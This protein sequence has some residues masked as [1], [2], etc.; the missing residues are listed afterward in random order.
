MQA[1]FRLGIISFA[2][3]TAFGLTACGGS[4]GSIFDGAGNHASVI[5]GGSNSTTGNTTTEGETDDVMEPG[6]S[7][8]FTTF[9]EWN[10]Q[11]A[12]GEAETVPKLYYAGR[13]RGSLHDDMREHFGATNADGSSRFVTTEGYY[14]T[15]NGQ[16]LRSNGAFDLSQLGNGY[17]DYNLQET[18]I[19]HIDG[20]RYTGTRNSRIQLY[21]QANSIVL[22][23]QTISGQLSDGTTTISLPEGALRIDQIKGEPTPEEDILRL[24]LD[25]T[26][27]GKQNFTYKGEAF[28]QAGR[29]TLVYSLDFI[30]QSGSGQITGLADKGTINLNQANIGTM[31]HTNPDDSTVLISGDSFEERT[32]APNQISAFGI[33]GVAQFESGSADGTYTLGF[34]GPNAVE[35][36]G[37]VTENNTNTVGFGGT[38][39]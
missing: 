8:Q 16:T 31:Q 34:F 38:K 28:S 12:V 13:M 14:A 4:D 11:S 17:Q 3:L 39:Q 6:D 20:K 7:D 25:V 26:N 5:G 24:T 2:V 1:T 15:L 37:I 23:K 30:D 18:S 33:Q 9:S 22:G 35:I 21:Q 29:G 36:A 32:T 19:S 10:V 27:Q